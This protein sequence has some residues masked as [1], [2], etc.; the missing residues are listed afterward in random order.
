MSFL[1][2]IGLIRLWENITTLV[3][4]KADKNEVENKQDTL[5]SGTNI[6]T[7]NGES[8]LGSGDITIEGGG[9]IDTSKFLDKT[10]IDTQNLQ[11]AV[12]NLDKGQINV[13]NSAETPTI[14][15]KGYIR[16]ISSDGLSEDYLTLDGAG[17]GVIATQTWVNGN[18]G[19]SFINKNNTDHQIMKG[20]LGLTNGAQLQ[21]F[22]NDETPTVYN[23]EY[24]RYVDSQGNNSNY[25]YFPTAANEGG[26]FATREWIDN[27]NFLKFNE[28]GQLYLNDTNDF[29]L[30]SDGYLVLPTNG[31]I[32]MDSANKGTMYEKDRVYFYNFPEGGGMPLTVQLLFPTETDASGTIATREWVEAQDFGGGSGGTVDT[33]DFVSKSATSQQTLQS[34]LS[35]QNGG[36]LNIFGYKD[37]PVVFDR[38]K[39]RYITLDGSGELNYFFN[40]EEGGVNTIATRGYV[41]EKIA[42][43][44]AELKAY[45]DEAILGG[46][47]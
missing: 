46:K 11:T 15:S 4:T 13:F 42:E 40:P 23:K 44:R 2:K 28:D 12:L 33:S 37:T 45:I 16:N 32:R 21:I 26:T 30:M 22:N 14:Y 10:S 9:S 38:E 17:S 29:Y 5:V 19:D 41:D 27:K 31:A 25:F 18:I 39:I 6:K 7:I 1:D 35:F 34:G 24:I 8:V 20:T 43:L 3:S 47:W 36:V